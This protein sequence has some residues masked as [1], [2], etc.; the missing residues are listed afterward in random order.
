MKKQDHIFRQLAIMKKQVHLFRQSMKKKGL[1]ATI[2]LDPFAYIEFLTFLSLQML[3]HQDHNTKSEPQLL[4][5]VHV[6]P[7]FKNMP[8]WL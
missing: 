6:A 1:Y 4:T 2:T 7:L 8:L 3:F 5:E